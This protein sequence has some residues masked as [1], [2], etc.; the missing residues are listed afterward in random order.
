VRD[1]IARQSD[2]DKASIKYVLEPG[3]GKYRHGTI[4]FAAKKGESV[5]LQNLQEK[6][7][8]TRLGKGTRSGVNYLD[9]T[10]E[11]EV[12]VVEKITVLKMKGSQF[13]LIDDPKA[14][15]KEG[16]KTP[17]QR[18]GEALAKGEKIANVS[19]R[20]QG[21]NG[22]WP[23]TLRELGESFTAKKSAALVVTDFQTV[24]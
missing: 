6:L 3:T 24:K 4:T 15:P 23:A 7:K 5:D 19:G 18:L 11:G 2:V 20:V 16:T 8:A 1:T 17:L 9:I 21:W 12:Q 14:K 13:T 10:A 22:V